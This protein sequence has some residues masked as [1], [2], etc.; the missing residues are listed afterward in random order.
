MKRLVLPALCILITSLTMT[1]AQ[2][3]LNSGE[4]FEYSFDALSG[5]SRAQG[6][7]FDNS[8]AVYLMFN[9]NLVNTGGNVR[10]EL[11]EEGLS[12]IADREFTIDLSAQPATVLAQGLW[13]DRDGSFRVTVVSGTLTFDGGAVIRGEPGLFPEPVTSGL[14]QN[15]FAAVP[16]P[17]TIAVGVLGAVAL[18][19][20]SRK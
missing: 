18:F 16:E 1:H 17:S 5:P 12:E 9:E 2:L 20:R 10:F 15:D 8:G 6:P 4:N 19:F 11:F 13:A 7:L 3:T 14:Y